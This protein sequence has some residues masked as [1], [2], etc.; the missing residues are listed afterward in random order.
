MTQYWLL[1]VLFLPC[2]LFSQNKGEN[3]TYGKI[4]VD[5][6]DLKIYSQAYIHYPQVFRDFD[7]KAQ[8]DTTSFEERFI[9]TTYANTIKI[10][11]DY[12]DPRVYETL[13]LDLREGL[14]DEIWFVFKKNEGYAS[15]LSR[16]NPEINSFTGMAWVYKGTLSDKEFEDKFIYQ[17]R[18]SFLKRKVRK[19][20]TDFRLYYHNSSQSFTIQLKNMNGFIEIEAYPRY[21]SLSRDI[22]ESQERY[23]KNNARYLKYLKRRKTK[24]DKNIIKRKNIFYRSI[25]EY[26]ENLWKSFQKN[27]MT[28]EERKLPREE[29]LR[30]YDKV[31]ANERKA[32]GNASPTLGN[33]I[34]SI[35]IDDYKIQASSVFFAT[36][37]STTIKTLYQNKKEEKLA[38]TDVLMIDVEAKTYKKYV[39]SK[40]IKVIKV[41][42]PENTNNVMVVWLRNGNV[43]FLTQKELRNLSV[44]KNGQSLIT[45]NIINKKFASVQTLRDQL[46]F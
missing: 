24:F 37:D 29:W 32:M 18:K 21:T 36:N 5:K 26:D 2:L 1:F 30:Y 35:R 7:R 34:R 11:P 39:G 46:N 15:L 3:A 14:E 22:R 19:Q 17:K 13:A 10:D 16:K 9:D 12:R 25:K 40:G 4:K 38:I 44:N 23:E 27:Y 33:I 45:L 8:F 31:I 20:W 6:K 42:N 28:E 43:G 41:D